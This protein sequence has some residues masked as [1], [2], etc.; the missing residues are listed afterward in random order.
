MKK[1]VIIS[2]AIMLLTIPASA[3][4]ITSVEI[5]NGDHINQ[6]DPILIWTYL[7]GNFNGDYFF[8]DDFGTN[9][10]YGSVPV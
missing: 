5:L 3:V 8:F 7:N 4:Q 9:I 6:N 10:Y 1:M 2:I